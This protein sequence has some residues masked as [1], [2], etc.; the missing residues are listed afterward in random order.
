VR[1]LGCQHPTALGAIRQ[2]TGSTAG[3]HGLGCSDLS[4]GNKPL[5]WRRQVSCDTPGLIAFDHYAWSDDGREIA[6]EGETDKNTWNV[7]MQSVA[8]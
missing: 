8:G 3:C 1:S 6:Y 7:C 2:W 4:P 5:I